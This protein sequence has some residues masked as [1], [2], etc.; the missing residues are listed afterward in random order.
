MDMNEIYEHK[1][2]QVKYVFKVC[3]IKKILQKEKLCPHTQICFY[4][5]TSNIYSL[6]THAGR[7]TVHRSDL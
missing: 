7:L 5:N 6:Y 4:R 1:K 2:P 3:N